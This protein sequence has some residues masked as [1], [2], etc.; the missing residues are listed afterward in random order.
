MKT[1]KFDHYIFNFK[2]IAISNPFNYYFNMRTAKI[3]CAMLSA[4]FLLFINLNTANA[5]NYDEGD[6]VSYTE[7]RYITSITADQQVVYFGTTGG[8]TR[9]DTFSESWLTPLTMV[10]GL[11]SNNVRAVVFDQQYGEL[12][13]ETDF[14]SGRY[15]ITFESWYTDSNFPSGKIINDWNPSRFSDLFLPFEYNYS[16]GIITDPNLQRYQIT[17]GYE[18]D[19]Y[20]KMYIGTWGMGAAI[21]NTEYREFKL[22]TYGPYDRRISRVVE[23]GNN[24][25]MGTRFTASSRAI[26]RF[27]K[28]R[29]KWDYY[30]SEFVNGLDNTEITSGVNSGKYTWLG[31]TSGLV[32]IDNSNHFRTFR[33][34]AGLPSLEILSLAEYGGHVYVGTDNGLTIMPPKGQIPDSTYKPPLPDKL[35]LRGY[36]IYDMYVF[37]DILYIGTDRNALAYDAR[38]KKLIDLDTPGGDLAYGVYDIFADDENLYFGTRFAVVMVNP[39]TDSLL[40]ATEHRY[41]SG[42]RIYQV[43]A[44]SKYIWAATDVGL[45]KY[46]KSDGYTYMYTVADG[47]PVN[48]VNSL[49]ADGDYFWL[50]TREGL[51]R[52]YWNDPHRG[53]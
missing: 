33:N 28:D 19:H 37:N 48:E 21:I 25:W 27:D 3:V 51:V 17:V 7:F 46:R 34:F 47:L 4:L 16:N 35:S 9:Y 53:D 22:L 12:W 6:W 40:V 20:Y 5:V 24:L 11:P 1:A 29:N 30:K 42:W 18:D 49:V 45:W 41:S 31:T 26:T 52:F 10:D 13:I 32:R 8:V 38:A 39:K 44:D 15:N 50:G 14:G 36:S 43:Y 2:T 23:I